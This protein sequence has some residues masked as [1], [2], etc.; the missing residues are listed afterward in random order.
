MQ[1][2]LS[3]AFPID[4]WEENHLDYI[5]TEINCTDD[6]IIVCQRK[7]AETRLFSLDIPKGADD[8]DYAG[9]ELVADNQ[10]LIG[11]LSWMSA[12]TRPDLT[13]SVSLAQQLQKGPTIGDVK[14]TNLISTRAVMFK[15]EGLRFRPIPDQT[16]GILTYHDAAWAN[17]LEAENEDEYFRLTKEDQL[18]GLQ[19]EGPFGDKRERKAKR[20]N[21][22]VASQIG[23]L[24]LFA[25][26]ACLRGG[27]GATS[28]GDWRSRA[29]QRVCRSTFGAEAQAC[30]EGLE[31]AQYI[32]SL[33]ETLMTG[34][35]VKVTEARM[36]IM[37]LSDCR[38]LYDHVH[39]QGVPRVPTDRRLAIDLAA[40]RQSLKSERWA[41]K[42]PLGWVPSN[43]QY[44]DILTK[45]GDPGEWWNAQKALLT[46]P[47]SLAEDARANDFLERKRTSVEHKVACDAD[48][49]GYNKVFRKSA[50][51]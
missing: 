1:A 37:C 16:F 47:I 36:P 20:Q 39:R 15:D 22:K 30:V 45:P 18:A 34:D 21:S 51:C 28:I 9:P 29:G 6:E 26:F 46:L 40:L 50:P 8:E 44:G 27:V 14:F 4:K 49:P 10:S 11:A 17:A 35:L 24:V 23:A 33:I 12:Q 48:R 38:S 3:E 41:T 5:G 25:D 42:L 31:G 7:Y 43:L 2:A 19:R 32:R 13:C